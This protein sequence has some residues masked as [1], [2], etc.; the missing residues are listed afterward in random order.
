M[1]DYCLEYFHPK[2]IGVSISESDAESLTEFK[3]PICHK[4]GN[5]S[6]QYYSEGEC[7]AY[8]K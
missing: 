1:C 4:K 6:P 2:C 8:G 7:I 5:N 3:C